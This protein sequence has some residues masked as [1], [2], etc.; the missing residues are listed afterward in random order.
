M[1]C[2]EQPV[3]FNKAR[4]ERSTFNSTTTNNITDLN[5]YE[6]KT[7]IQIQLKCVFVYRMPLRHFTDIG[8]IH[9]PLKMDFSKMSPRNS[10]GK[11]V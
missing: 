10:F 8:K 11:T 3:Y 9:F 2:S 4:L 1:L 5:V 7:K 6:R